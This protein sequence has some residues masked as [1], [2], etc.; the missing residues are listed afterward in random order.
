LLR[1]I[2]LFRDLTNQAGAGGM[3]FHY[4]VFIVGTRVI[5]EGLNAEVPEDGYCLNLSCKIDSIIWNS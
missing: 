3:A 5:E 1:Q 4:A 2:A